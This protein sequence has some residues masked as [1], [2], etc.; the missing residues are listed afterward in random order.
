METKFKVAELTKEMEKQNAIEELKGNF[1]SHNRT[2]FAFIA[3]EFR[4][5][6]NVEKGLDENN[7]KELISYVS[8]ELHRLSK[9]EN[10]IRKI[11][12]INSSDSI[13]EIVSNL[14]VSFYNNH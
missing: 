14:L 6:F 4:R 12:G 3:N 11:L 7:F 2:I 10:N 9:Q 8:N 1:E 5:Y 13:E